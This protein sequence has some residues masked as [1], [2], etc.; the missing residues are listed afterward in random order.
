[1]QEDS[2]P[3]E[4]LEER[5]RALTEQCD[6][7]QGGL[8]VCDW[9]WM[10]AEIPL[11]ELFEDA[12]PKLPVCLQ[13]FKPLRGPEK[14]EYVG[15]CMA[16]LTD[17]SHLLHIPALWDDYTSNLQRFSPALFSEN[18]CLPCRM[19]DSYLDL[20]QIL[21]PLQP[22]S[23]SNLAT[24]VVNSPLSQLT[25]GIPPTQCSLPQKW[26][27]GLGMDVNC[28]LPAFKTEVLFT[29]EREYETICGR[30]SAFAGWIGE[31]ADIVGKTHRDD[32]GREV[33]NRLRAISDIYT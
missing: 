1:M 12:C 25:L 6:C 23:S 33:V 18:L 4:E 19:A 29:I 30:T 24:A 14:S 9:D 15:K 10:W 8:S 17:F 28:P 11:L 31:L 27:R 20:R 26:T 13:T 2:S 7:V 16:E 22:N 5:I 21:Q 3:R 32:E